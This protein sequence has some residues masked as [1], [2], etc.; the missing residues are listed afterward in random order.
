MHIAQGRV[1]D[2]K[3]GGLLFTHPLMSGWGALWSDTCCCCCLGWCK[4]LAPNPCIR[5]WIYSYLLVSI[6]FPNNKAKQEEVAWIRGQGSQPL[7]LLLLDGSGGTSNLMMGCWGDERQSWDT[8]KEEI[9]Q[10]KKLLFCERNTTHCYFM[11]L[12]WLFVYA[13]LYDA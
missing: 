2:F 13:N 6:P 5:Q 11:G 12:V 9:V 3:S 1:Q 7:M 10:L 8:I 4:I